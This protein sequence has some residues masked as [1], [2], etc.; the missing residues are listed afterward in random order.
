M[1]IQIKESNSVISKVKSK[2]KENYFLIFFGLLIMLLS[3][4]SLFRD[5]TLE[6]LGVF[7]FGLVFST[8]GFV[9]RTSDC[10]LKTISDDKI[11]LN[12]RNKEIVLYFDDIHHMTQLLGFS[13]YPILIV[14]KFKFPN[15][16]YIIINEPYYD[17]P[18]I[19]KNKG[20]ELRNFH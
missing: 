20:I 11:I 7:L 9:F 13:K 19:F 15:K 5:G 3:F 18:S 16:Y 10:I 6:F 1:D 4:V 12:N 2:R 14:T 17:Y 8:V